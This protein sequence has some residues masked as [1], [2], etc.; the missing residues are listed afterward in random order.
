LHEDLPE[1][2][3]TSRPRGLIVS[4]LELLGPFARGSRIPLAH[5]DDGHRGQ[6]A[7]LSD[8]PTGLEIVIS[9][10]GLDRVSQGQLDEFDNC[11]LADG[12]VVEVLGAA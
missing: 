11:L 7:A 12:V 9:P 6:Y 2:L 1:R 5:V 10:I 4:A 3:N 8:E